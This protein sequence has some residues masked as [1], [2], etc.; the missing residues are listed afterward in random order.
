MRPNLVFLD[1]FEDKY[2][3]TI[4]GKGVFLA[5]VLLGYMA[6]LQAGKKDDIHSAPLFKQMNFGRMTIR[7]LK[8]HLSRVPELINAYNMKYSFYLQ[9][10]ANEVGKLL[11]EGGEKELGVDGNF[12]FTIA[13]A[14]A[15]NYFWNYI[16]K[17]DKKE[18]LEHDI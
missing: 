12:A 16:F 4:Q 1:S 17:T 2:L 9:Q 10:L 11:L 14:D 7:D 8:K 6:E 3:K 15:S 18:E 13:F 5:G